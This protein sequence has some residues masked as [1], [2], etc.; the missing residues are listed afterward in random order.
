[1]KN[2]RPLVIAHRG[3]SAKYPENTLAAFRAALKAKADMIECDLHLTRDARVVVTHDYE[4]GRCIPGKGY[5][6]QADYATLVKA[7]SGQWFHKKF[8]RERLPLLEEL[9]ALT[10]DAPVGLNL[11]IKGKAQERFGGTDA[12]VKQVYA[13]IHEWGMESRVL[14]SSFEAEVLISASTLN[15][16]LKS[17]VRLGVLDHEPH[18]G[19]G[20]ANKLQLA[21]KIR[22][23]SYHPNF[24]ELSWRSVAALHEKGLRVFPYTVNKKPEFEHLLSLGVDG[25][26][27]NEVTALHRHLL[28]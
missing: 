5:V 21:E 3:F 9:L 16:R 17:P 1:M 22:A 23:Y 4:L 15:T 25:M 14:I 28:R 13:L 19:E 20:F 2:K 27:T 6:V 10:I 12:F 18:A 26:I 7:S 24:K 8:A 11:E